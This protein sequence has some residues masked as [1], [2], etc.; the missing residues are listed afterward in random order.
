M[1]YL[2]MHLQYTIYHG[3]DNDRDDN[4]TLKLHHMNI[5]HHC[6][7]QLCITQQMIL[8]YWLYYLYKTR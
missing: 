3:D 1:L 7:T 5:S 2:H 8:L 4:I 6:E